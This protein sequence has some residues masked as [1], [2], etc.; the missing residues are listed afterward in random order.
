MMAMS[1]PRRPRFIAC[2][3]RCEEIP[4]YTSRAPDAEFVFASYSD[5][6]AKAIQIDPDRMGEAAARFARLHAEQPFTAILNRKEKCVVPAAYLASVLGLPPILVAPDLA[7]DKYEMRR[8]LNGTASFPGTVLIRDAGDLSH[9]SDAMFPAVLKPRFGFNSR[10]AVRVSDRSELASA[11]ADQYAHYSLLTKQDGTNSD[12]VVEEFIA[13]TEH[14]VESLLK[15]GRVLFHLISDKMGMQPPFFIEMGD[16]MPSTLPPAAQHAC[17]DA[18]GKAIDALG[19]RNGWTHTEVKWH[20]DQVLVVES[21]A[22]MGGGYFEELIE[23]VFGIDRM[24][25]LIGMYRGNAPSQAPASRVHAAARR[26]VVYGAERMRILR[27]PEILTRD[28][29]IKLVWPRRVD[30]INRIMTGP[31]FDFNNTLFEFMAVGTSAREAEARADGVLEEA[32][33]SEC[34]P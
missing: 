20:G 34:G 22:R 9:V 33:L 16:N 23:T 24:G 17:M 25:M 15:D 13:G 11:Y 10:S 27:N 31:P 21:A 30:Q 1:D 4:D 8:A 3:S 12:F 6:G 18:A 28:S 29:H 2:I 14:N 5:L 26:V 7:R 19:I 32:I